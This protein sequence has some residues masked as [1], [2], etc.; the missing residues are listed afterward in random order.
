VKKNVDISRRKFLVGGALLGGAIVGGIGSSIIKPG[1][2]HGALPGFLPVPTN[3]LNVNVVKKRAYCYWYYGLC[4]NAAASSLIEA[5]KD[6]FGGVPTGTD[7]DYIPSGPQDTW[8]TYGAGGVGMWGTIC[9]VPNGC[10]AVLNLMGLVSLNS[11][12]EGLTSDWVDQI[13]RY[14]SQTSFP[15]SLDDIYANDPDPS[16]PWPFA[17]IPDSAVMAHTTSNSPLCHES[18]SKWANAAGVSFMDPTPGY[19]ASPYGQPGKFDRCA[20]VAS[21]GAA[22]TAGLINAYIASHAIPTDYTTPDLTAGCISCHYFGGRDTTH[23]PDQMGQMDC[24]ECHTDNK[25]HR[26]LSLVIDDV[27]TADGS[28]SS[29]STFTGGDPIQYKVQFSILGS[30]SCFMKTYK[31]RAAGTCGKI[32]GLPK[33]ETLSTGAYEWTWSGTVPGGCSG[34]AKVIMDLKMFDYQGGPLQAE[35]KKIH[36]FTIT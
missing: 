5:I 6:S 10:I 14:Y 15:I 28:G 27:W 9:G 8:Y 34:T 23:S 22:F 31:S 11:G 30:G 20:K 26:A 16:L 17:P 12:G 4:M 7:W 3:P 29:K 24:A 35:A 25:P 21:A 1:V 13:M 32:Q 2:A 36:K 18:V 19:T 33:N